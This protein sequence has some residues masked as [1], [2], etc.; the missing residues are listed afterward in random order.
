MTDCLF[1][2]MIAGEITPDKV[3]ETDHLLAFRDIKPQAPSHI[4]IIPKQ[5]VAT[6]NDL[7]QPSLAGELLF[8]VKKVAEIEGL[9][10]D[11]YRT[12][13]NCNVNGGQEVYHLHLHVLGGR[14]MVWPPG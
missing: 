5:H 4:L 13:I 7:D 9:T 2:K 6:L 8:G 12:I 1:C 14:Q 3:Y 10:A 11:G